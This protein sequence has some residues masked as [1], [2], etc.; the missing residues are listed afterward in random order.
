M[1]GHMRG[2][3]AGPCRR[4]H[5]PP[6]PKRKTKKNPVAKAERRLQEAKSTVAQRSTDRITEKRHWKA[7]R[8]EKPSTLQKT[9]EG[10]KRTRSATS[11]ERHKPGT[12]QARQ[13]KRFRG[14]METRS[15]GSKLRSTPTRGMETSPRLLARLVGN[16]SQN[17]RRRMGLERQASCRQQRRRQGWHETK[18][19]G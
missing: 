16:R 12:A 17:H 4:R 3:V 13:S 19:R 2:R 6:L 7:E 15:R 18:G 8:Q 11:M 9:N 1:V 14:Q 10:R 5:P